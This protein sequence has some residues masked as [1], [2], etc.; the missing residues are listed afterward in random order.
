M[1]VYFTE[2]VIWKSIKPDPY[3]VL[4]NRP[5]QDNTLF[6]DAIIVKAGEDISKSA[7]DIWVLAGAGITASN[8]T[9]E[10]GLKYR[11]GKRNKAQ[12]G[13]DQTQ[14]FPT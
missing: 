13:Q 6:P 12:Q 10:V 3:S 2:T 11:M 9:K 7:A 8:L 14:D 4:R 1:S 5:L